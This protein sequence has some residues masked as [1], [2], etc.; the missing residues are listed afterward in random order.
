MK[1]A[2]AIAAVSTLFVSAARA[3]VAAPPSPVKDA[4]HT[5]LKDADDRQFVEQVASAGMAETEMGRLALKR[6]NSADVKSFAQMMVTDHTKANTELK[7]LATKKKFPV[8]TEMTPE[9]RQQYEE[10]AKLN[11]KDFDEK[12]MDVMSKQHEKDE[13]VFKEI[14]SKGQDKDLQRWAEKTLPVIQ[15]HMQKSKATEKK[16]D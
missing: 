2:L 13:E 4:A 11:G 12:Y 9:Q 14:A 16:V 6:A 8:P 10:L 5:K 3:Q 15:R 1:I 7:K